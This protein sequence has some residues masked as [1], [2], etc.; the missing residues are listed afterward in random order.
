MLLQQVGPHFL[1]G[2]A[3]EHVLFAVKDPGLMRGLP[4]HEAGAGRPTN[5]GLAIGGMKG[6]GLG[7]D[8]V[9]VWCFQFCAEKRFVFP[10]RDRVVEAEQQDVFGSPR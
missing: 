8:P 6:G 7:A 10:E 2:D 1:G 9:E 4:G 5:G 3:D